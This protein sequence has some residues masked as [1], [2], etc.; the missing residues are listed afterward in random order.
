[1][2]KNFFTVLFFYLPFL[3]TIVLACIALLIGIL[4]LF[5]G[6]LLVL[7]LAFYGFYALTRDVGLLEWIY[8]RFCSYQES[9]ETIFL[10]NL[11]KSFVLRDETNIPAGPALYICE[12]H[13][14]ISYSWVLHFIYKIHA[15]PSSS[16]RPILAAHSMLFQIPFLK[17]VLES[18]HFI[19]S[20]EEKIKEYLGKGKSVALLV[21][22]IEEMVYNGEQPVQL[23]LKKRKGY[24]RIAKEMNVPLVPLFTKGENELF[25][26]PSFWPWKVFSQIL[27]KTTGLHIPLPSWKSVKRWSS[28]LEK[29]FSTP[30]ET[31][32]LEPIQTTNKQ[33]P[34]IR[35][36]TIQ[37]FHRFFQTKQI[38]ATFKA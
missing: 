32:V 16:V 20:S 9:F 19:D 15:W 7:C 21:G 1:M 34:E 5:S 29:P 3:L 23:I 14:L 6:T 4:A 22:G 13:G 36:E 26:S 2:D 27:Y 33:E 35:N 11:Q 38:E 31:F 10:Q 37:R 17:D 18:F 30:V 28:L 12:P 8:N 24:A 25:P